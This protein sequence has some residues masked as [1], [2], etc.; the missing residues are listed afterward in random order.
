MPEVLPDHVPMPRAVIGWDGT[1]YRAF[2]VD[3]A[4]HL[5]LDV[6][7]NV[8]LDG[9]LQSVSTDRLLTAADTELPAATILADGMANPTTPLVG[10]VSLVF[11]G[12]T[13]DIFRGPEEHIL[14]ASALRTAP[15]SSPVQTNY[16]SRGV[17]IFVDVTAR[18]GDETITVYLVFIDPVSG[19]AFT[20]AGTAAINAAGHYGIIAY[21]GVSAGAAE[22][23]VFANIPL[24][25]RWRVAVVHTGTGSMTYSIG[26]CYVM[27]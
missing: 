22:M 3:A 25:R 13:W 5:Q 6:L 21:P 8:N 2:A 18:V 27:A 20:I 11:N 4:G 24:P 17:L 1:R 12:G 14:L 16:S 23:T 7:S 15:I 19:D 26:A 9:A 10:M